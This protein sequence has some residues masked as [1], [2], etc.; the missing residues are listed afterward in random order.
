MKTRIITLLLIIGLSVA[1]AAEAPK[2]PPAATP[3]AAATPADGAPKP[4]VE[5][6]Q[7][8]LD[9]ARQQIAQLRAVAEE[10]EKQRNMFMNTRLNEAAAA[11]VKKQ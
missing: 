5:S 8:E 3:A 2:A 9:E 7:K 4:T 10:L 1:Y 6:L 11:A